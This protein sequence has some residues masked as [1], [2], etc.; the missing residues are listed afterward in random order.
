MYNL[1]LTNEAKADLFRIYQNG[2]HKFGELQADKYLEQ[3]YSNFEKIESN[4][5]MFPQAI[6]KRGVDTI[7]YNIIGFEIE[8]ITIIGRQDFS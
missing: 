7:F 1:N 3:F 5:F 6:D 4:P 8:I 2:F